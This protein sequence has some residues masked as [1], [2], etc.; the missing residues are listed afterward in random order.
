M[1]TRFLPEVSASTGSPVA[2]EEQ[3]LH[4]LAQLAA[5]RGGRLDGCAG[6]LGKMP[7]VYVEAQLDR[8]S[9]E[10]L[11]SVRRSPQLE[12]AADYSPAA[13]LDRDSSTP[14]TTPMATVNSTATTMTAPAPMPIAG[15]DACSAVSASSPGSRK[16]MATTI[17]R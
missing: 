11:P 15:L 4:D 16:Y 1:S 3:R 12:S 2:L 17:R 10:P 8:R 5:H 14:G 6:A 13:V 9:I 7:N